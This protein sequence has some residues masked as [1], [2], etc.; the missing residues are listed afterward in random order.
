M[1]AA[2]QNRKV[3]VV[4]TVVEGALDALK[5][6]DGAR[7]DELVAAAVSRL[8]DVDAIVLGQFSLARARNLCAKMSR[9]IIITT[10]ESAVEALKAEIEGGSSGV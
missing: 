8:H 4:S 2:A 10:P 6:G 9:I 1:M 7:H 5:A 3:A